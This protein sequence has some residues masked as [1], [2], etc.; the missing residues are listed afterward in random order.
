MPFDPK[1]KLHRFFSCA[2]VSMDAPLPK[3]DTDED[4]RECVANVLLPHEV[5]G[6]LYA[7]D[8]DQVRSKT[9]ARDSVYIFFCFFPFSVRYPAFLHKHHRDVGFSLLAWAFPASSMRDVV[10]VCVAVAS[11]VAR[12]GAP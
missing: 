10:D 9:Y 11:E 5:F 6:A 1:S 7:R 8:P 3:V 4:P 12:G 2:P